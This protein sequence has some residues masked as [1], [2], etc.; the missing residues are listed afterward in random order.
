[1]IINIDNSVPCNGKPVMT[2][3]ETL[4]LCRSICMQAVVCRMRLQVMHNNITKIYL[5][6]TESKRKKLT[7]RG[8]G[9]KNYAKEYMA[10]IKEYHK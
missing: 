3:S 9:N 2:V 5:I 4:R 10:L 8:S 7:I 6:L 1:M